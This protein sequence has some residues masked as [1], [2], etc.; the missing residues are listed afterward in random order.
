MKHY[1]IFISFCTFISCNSKEKQFKSKQPHI[2]SFLVETL[3]SNL[4]KAYNEESIELLDSFLI[5]WSNSVK[6]KNKEYLKHQIERD[7]YEIYN[8]IFKP[9]NIHLV[10]DSIYNSSYKINSNYIILQTNI[11]YFIDNLDDSEVV[12]E[13]NIPLLWDFRPEYKTQ[14]DYGILYLSQEYELAL[15]K[16]LKLKKENRNTDWLQ[17]SRFLESKLSLI[18]SHNANFWYLETHP[19]VMGINFNQNCDTASAYYIIEYSDY[20]ADLIKEKDKW[21]LVKTECLGME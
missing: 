20:H 6:P 3:S 13:A 10:S 17:R 16:F 21:M 18:L 8:L 9:E 14:N 5:N 19:R 12:R 4:E 11:H 1:I 2:D 7:I 15:R